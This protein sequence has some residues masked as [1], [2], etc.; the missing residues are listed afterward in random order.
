MNAWR[1]LIPRPGEALRSRSSDAHGRA[2]KICRRL[3]SSPRVRIGCD[4]APHPL[5]RNASDQRDY[6][7]RLSRSHASNVPSIGERE[8]ANAD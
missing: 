5:V 7:L 3:S 6:E 4:V 8:R 2:T 1:P